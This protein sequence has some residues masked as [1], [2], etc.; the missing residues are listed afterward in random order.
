MNDPKATNRSLVAFED[1]SAAL[2]MKLAR[3]F[4]ESRELSWFWLEMAMEEKQHAVLLDFCDA[5][6]L[7]QKPPDSDAIQR[8]SK[9][10]A[11]LEERAD[12]RDLSLDEAFLIA[13]ELEASELNTTYAS[14]IRSIHGT[15]YI[16]RRKIETLIPD[17]MKSLLEAAGKF[18]VS[19]PTMARMVELS[20][21]KGR[22]S[23]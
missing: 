2:Y 9:M 8:L 15:D 16:L 23:T 7:L 11:G 6:Q 14:L 21:E 3:L 19:A 20:G 17:H 12:R 13:A 1:R 5:E 18:G 22:S 10:L 4:A